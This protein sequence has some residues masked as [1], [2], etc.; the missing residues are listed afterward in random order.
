ML[1]LN[2]L[3]LVSGVF[4][5]SLVILSFWRNDQLRKKLCY[6]TIMVLSC[7]DLLALFP[8]HS[9][10]A[11]LTLYWL[12]TGQLIVWEWLHTTFL[13]ANL[14]LGFPLIALLVMNFDRYLATYYPLF[15]RTSVTRGKLLIPFVIL[16]LA[17]AILTVSSHFDFV[18]PF[19][20]FLAICCVIFLMPMIF[21]NYK[22]FTIARKSTRNKKKSPEMR[23]TFS[24]KKISSCLLSTAC[25]TVL[26][27][28]IFVYIWLS[29]TSPGEK[30][31]LAALW[32]RTISS[33]NGTC[34][35]LIF[36]WKNNVLRAEGMKVIKGIK[37]CRRDDS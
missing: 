26:S 18:I 17:F 33:M 30:A 15:H 9:Y 22:L 32:V 13:L 36:F 27:I 14:L 3:F 29:I 31:F 28:P 6:F 11:F 2:V 19:P 5:N 24:L 16:S 7:F 21:F 34:N 25:F 37:F 8:N 20:V 4:L 10:T 1:A 23:R 12:I 35:C